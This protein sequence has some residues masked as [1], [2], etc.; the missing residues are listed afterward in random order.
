MNQRLNK[1]L[2]ALKAKTTK[3]K[4]TCC[5]DILFLSPQRAPVTM[6]CFAEV[7]CSDHH[8]DGSL[9]PRMPQGAMRAGCH[10]NPNQER[11]GVETTGSAVT[12]TKLRQDW[13]EAVSP[14]SAKPRRYQRFGAPLSQHFPSLSQKITVAQ[15]RAITG[16]GH[17]C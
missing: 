12:G 2:W 5:C 4:K 13:T 8:G 3:R 1:P 17:R 11:G 9:P 15:T 14:T 10:T 16:R 7:L 6:D